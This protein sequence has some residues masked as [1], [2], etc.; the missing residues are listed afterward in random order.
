MTADQIHEIRL[1]VYA[2][3]INAERDLAVALLEDISQSLGRR[4]VINEILE[5]VLLDIGERWTREELSLAQG[6]IAGKVAE[7]ILLK[8]ARECQN[9]IRPAKGPVVIGNIEDDHHSL[10]RRMVGIFLEAA[11]WEVLDLGNDVPAEDFVDKAVECGARIIGVSAMMLTTAEGIAD[12]RRILEERGLGGQI[13]LAVGGAVFNLR[14]ELAIQLGGDGT[15]TNAMQAPAL[16]DRLWQQ[17]A[18]AGEE[19]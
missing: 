2:S 16:F 6:Y 12:V 4:R 5:P 3:I 1:R 17:A 10:G 8:A 19:S 9:P 7:D 13:Q 15:C 18:L 14:P 11:G